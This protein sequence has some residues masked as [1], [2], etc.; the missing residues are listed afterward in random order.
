VPARLAR[1]LIRLA[2]ETT[3]SAL[4]PICLSREELSQMTGT[5]LFTVSRLL[6]LWAEAEILTVDR[7]TVVIDDLP[8][9]SRIAETQAA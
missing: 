2:G 3:H 5:C 1:L 4:D 8:R 9:L 6:S 7:K